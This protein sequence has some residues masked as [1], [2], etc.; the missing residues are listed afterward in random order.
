MISKQT[1]DRLLS[2]SNIISFKKKKKFAQVR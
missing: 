1:D 2:Y